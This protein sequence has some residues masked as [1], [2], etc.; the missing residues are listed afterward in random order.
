MSTVQHSSQQP[1]VYIWNVATTTEEL[2]YNFSQFKCKLPH[3]ASWSVLSS[4][5]LEISSQWGSSLPKQSQQ[6]IF[7]SHLPLVFFPFRLCCIL[8]GSIILSNYLFFTSIVFR[9]LFERI[10][11]WALKLQSFRVYFSTFYKRPK[12]NFEED[13]V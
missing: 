8:A 10:Q 4:T 2:N 9:I 13:L 6:H 5:H 3:V 12:G 11:I 1:H 7:L